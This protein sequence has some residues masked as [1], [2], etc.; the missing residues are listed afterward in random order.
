M[1]EAIMPYL[2]PYTVTA[3]V[4]VLVGLGYFLNRWYMVS[5]YRY[6]GTILLIAIF[7]SLGWLAVAKYGIS[8]YWIGGLYALIL[9]GYAVKSYYHITWKDI[10]GKFYRPKPTI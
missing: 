7:L 6:G 10:T 5:P 1:L 8:L 4:I 3:A 9:V 2:N